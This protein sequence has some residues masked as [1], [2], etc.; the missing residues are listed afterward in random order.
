M[1][2]RRGKQQ[3]L[4]IM[5]L[6]YNNRLIMKYRYTSTLLTVLNYLQNDGHNLDPN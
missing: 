1:T 2:F 5:Q 3:V 4:Q 6:M